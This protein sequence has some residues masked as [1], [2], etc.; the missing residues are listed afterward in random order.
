MIIVVIVSSCYGHEKM[1]TDLAGDSVTCFV[2]NYTD[3]ERSRAWAAAILSSREITIVLTRLGS[4]CGA[5][6]RR[7]LNG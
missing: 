7:Y 1:Q 5:G 2:M 3:V 4:D 6:W